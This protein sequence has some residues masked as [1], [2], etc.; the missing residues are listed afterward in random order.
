MAPRKARDQRYETLTV[1]QDG[2]VLT[3]RFAHPP[4]NFMPTGFL[5]DLDRLTHAV[6][7]DPSVGAVILTSGVDG[8]FLI[9]VDPRELGALQKLPLPRVSQRV[10][11]WFVPLFN[12][13]LSIPGLVPAIE[14]FGGNVGKGVVWGFRWKR[15]ILRMNRSGTVYLAALNGHAME[16]GQEI[17]LACDLRYASDDPNLRMGNLELLVG[18]IPGG[19]GTAR[20]LR[21]MG[22][23]GALEHVL[24][25]APL[26]GAQA[27]ATGL[28]H[29]II[30]AAR[31][32]PEVQAIAARMARRSP[33]SVA[34]VKRCLY[35]GSDHSFSEALDM[36]M[37]GF[38]ASGMTRGS[39]RALQPFLDDLD[40][41]GDTPF[42]AD[43]GPWVEGTRADLVS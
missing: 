9:H 14:R 32:L 12:L 4:L 7:R 21:M 35:F 5:R 22:T 25:A 29:R 23:A 13:I 24:E 34:A 33:T 26:T 17:V 11:E 28:V 20:M 8:R 10:L 6:D 42:L 3:V 31:L 30:P 19:G 27:L 15:T 40:R 1:E 41:L 39:R 36:E 37:A 43:P 2:R 18:V 16:G 38:I